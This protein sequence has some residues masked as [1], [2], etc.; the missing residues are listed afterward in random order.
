MSVVTVPESVI[1]SGVTPLPEVPAIL[2][3]IDI[4]DLPAGLKQLPL[5]APTHQGITHGPSVKDPTQDPTSTEDKFQALI[6]MTSILTEKVAPLA[7]PTVTRETNVGKLYDAQNPHLA[8][9]ISKLRG[10]YHMIGP[11]ASTDSHALI[12][13]DL[14][15]R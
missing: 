6:A 8:A 12:T 2:P 14:Y 1:K 3:H 9:M 10:N 7:T 15:L 11:L 13:Q 4:R 5:D